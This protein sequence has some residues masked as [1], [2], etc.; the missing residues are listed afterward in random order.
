MDAQALGYVQ[1]FLAAK[2]DHADA[3]ALMGELYSR[4][5]N[6]PLAESELL[7]AISLY[8][9]GAKYHHLLGDVYLQQGLESQALQ[10]FM[11]GYCLAE[12]GDLRNNLQRQIDR[13]GGVLPA[14]SPGDSSP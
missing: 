9:E 3:H 13:L 8:P 10:A 1:V 12:P 6:W 11:A 14:C 4:R 2:P 7:W 5:G